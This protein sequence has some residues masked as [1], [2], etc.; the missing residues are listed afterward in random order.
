MEIFRV[1]AT[2]VDPHGEHMKIEFIKDHKSLDT[3]YATLMKWVEA[4][5][6]PGN[7][8]LVKNKEMDYTVWADKDTGPDYIYSCKIERDELFD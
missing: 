1:I 3:A 4:S 7:N 8:H 6:E 5:L 2:W